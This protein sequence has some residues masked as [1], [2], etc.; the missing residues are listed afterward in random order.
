MNGSMIEGNTQEI[1]CREVAYCSS[2]VC[3]TGWASKEKDKENKALEGND[4]YVCCDRVLYCE[5]FVCPR[6]TEKKPSAEDVAGFSRSACCQDIT[7]CSAFQCPAGSKLKLDASEIS[8]SDQEACC[9]EDDSKP[10]ADASSTAEVDGS[11][12]VPAPSTE[13]PSEPKC[14]TFDCPEGFKKKDNAETING[15][16]KETCCDCTTPED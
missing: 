4:K 13:N 1:C 5:D 2:F 9:D 3:P 16:D 8:G 15:S 14:D 12:E 7:M 6:G 10:A 11:P